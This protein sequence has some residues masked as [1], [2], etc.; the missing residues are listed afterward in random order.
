MTKK[1]N[2]E[3]RTHPQLKAEFETSANNM[4]SKNGIEIGDEI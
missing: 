3:Q 4:K 1:W 2:L